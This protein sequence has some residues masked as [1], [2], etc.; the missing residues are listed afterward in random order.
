MSLN[1]RGLN[2]ELKVRR[3]EQWQMKFNAFKDNQYDDPPTHSGYHAID[4]METI[5]E[6]IEQGEGSNESNELSQA[7]ADNT[8]DP[9]QEAKQAEKQEEDR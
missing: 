4:I 8:D 6:E 1:S 3:L 5:A 7:E 9:S 2:K